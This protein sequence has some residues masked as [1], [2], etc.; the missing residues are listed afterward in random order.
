MTIKQQ[1]GIF[2]RNPTFNNVDIENDLTVEGGVTHNG[3][4]DITGQ[5]NV[6]NLRLDGNTVSTTDTNGSLVLNPNGTGDVDIPLSN[7]GTVNINSSIYTDTVLDMASAS[8]SG[9]TQT[10]ITLGDGTYRNGTLTAYGSVYGGGLNYAVMLA[11]NTV[12]SSSV[13][14]TFTYS[15]SAEATRLLQQGGRHYLQ[16]APSGTAGNTIS[17]Q[18]AFSTTTSGNIAFPSGQGI[19]FSATSGTGTSELFD[20]YEEG[21]WTPALKNATTTAYTTQLGRYTKVGN[22]VYCHVR[23]QI[24][25][26]GDGDPNEIVGFPF[27]ADT[28]G[29]NGHHASF[30]YYSSAVNVIALYSNLT[31]TT[32]EVM[33][34]AAAGATPSNPANVFGDGRRLD[35]SIAYRAS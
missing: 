30:G 8:G 27:T 28:T 17:W 23:L 26:L 16:Y 33:A 14:G 7:G 5:L 18:T 34:S 2:G 15:A 6:D 10:R 19:D 12:N 24:T 20:D 4:Q 22:M 31:G 11:S 32:M 25:T 3:T 21:T 29:G 35:F 1:G 13:G 9:G